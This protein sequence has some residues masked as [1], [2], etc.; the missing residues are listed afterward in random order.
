MKKENL[1]LGSKIP[2][3][4]LFINSGVNNGIFNMSCDNYLLDLISNNIVSQPILRIYGW[5]KPTI[6]IG[7]NQDLIDIPKD[8]II[9]KRATG[10]QAVKHGLPNEELTYSVL[11]NYGYKVKQLYHEIGE[12]LILF[13]AQYDLKGV[14]GYSSN[15]YSKQFDCF[16]SKTEA[17]I[18]VNDI[19]VIGSAQYRKKEYVLQH[20]SIKLDIIQKLSGKY[21]NFKDA[22]I[23][24]KDSFADKLKIKFVDYT[25][26][27]NQMKTASTKTEKHSL[28]EVSNIYNLPFLD[29]IFKAQSIHRQNQPLNKVQLC[30]LSNIK[31]GNCPEDCKYCPQSSRHE[32]EVEKYKLLSKDIVLEQA[33]KA[34][35]NGAT[36]FCMGAAWRNAPTNN[37]FENVLE[38]VEEVAKLKM[39]VCCTL[40]ML[41]QEQA[42]KLKKAG[43][44]AYNHNLDTSPEFYKEII[45]TRTYEDRLN[46]IEHVSNAGIQVC[47]GGILGL[48]ESQIDRISLIKTLANLNPQPE[49]V[50]INV[51]VK[52][53]GTLLDSVEAIDPFEIIRSIA[54]S[55]ILMPKAKVRLSAGR[56]E[57]SQELQALAFIAGANS[58]FMGERLLTTDNPN[59]NED[60]D[61]FKKLRIEPL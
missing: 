56:L 60:K 2:S 15:N 27:E 6:S 19:K 9:V 34:K 1:N 30:T 4:W 14:I 13:L 11:I 41:T 51:L 18:V 22:G 55:R 44:T 24:L 52:V 49:S 59:I 20:G 40:G 43:L 12:A 26:T 39:E 10:G 31:S 38:I 17:D 37:E 25:L 3:N 47:C 42:I 21:I 23:K 5:D 50:P 32:T 28:E 54:T 35:E 61:L 8:Y 45:T 46:T 29:L 58:I 53:K 36:R 33:T 48:G 7:A 57:M 16:N